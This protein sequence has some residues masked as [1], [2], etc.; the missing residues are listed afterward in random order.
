MRTKSLVLIIIAL[1]CGLVAS[2]GISEVLKQ[3]P[4]GAPETEQILVAAI[5]IDIGK[6]L[7]AQNVKVEEWP[8]GKIIEGAFHSLD[9]V[10]DQYTRSRMY[11][12]EPVLAAKLMDSKNDSAPIP[13]GYRVL[14]V[15]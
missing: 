11:A 6:K 12:G 7:D 10:K 14:P 4:D 13:E 3:K 15:K 2:I 9:E 1:G 5:D 8:K